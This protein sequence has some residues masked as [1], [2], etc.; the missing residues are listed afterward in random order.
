MGVG[1]LRFQETVSD[2][3]TATFLCVGFS[4]GEGGCGI[5]G[6]VRLKHDPANTHSFPETGLGCLDSS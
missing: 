5:L 3:K 2:I 1:R 6:C 4:A